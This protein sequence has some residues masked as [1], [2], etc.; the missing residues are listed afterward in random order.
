MPM[1]YRLKLV[2]AVLLSFQA[3]EGS[4]AAENAAASESRLREAVTYLASDALEGRGIGTAWLDKAAEYIAARFKDLGLRSNLFKG[5]PFQEFDV[6]MAAEMGP[7]E[8]NRL[9]CTPATSG[10]TG[11]RRIE[12]ELGKTFTPLAVGGTAAVE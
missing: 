8:H 2:F 9:A 4:Y 11:P 5:T 3:G 6:P 7:A 1:K 10:A 12:L